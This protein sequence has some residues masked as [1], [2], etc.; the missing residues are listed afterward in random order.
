MKLA[1]PCTY[2]D[3]HG[4]E[5]ALLFN[6]GETLSMTLRDVDFSG[7]DFDDLRPEP[8]CS[9]RALQ[10]FTFHSG[11]LCACTLSLE[12]PITVSVRGEVRTRPLHAHLILGKAR[13]SGSGLEDERLR[14]AITLEGKRYTTSGK[15]GWFDDELE[16]LSGL[17]PAHIF[18]KICHGCALSH[19]PAAGYGL[20]GGLICFKRHKELART[21]AHKSPE[22]WQ[23][24]EEPVDSWVQET[25]VCG[26]FEREGGG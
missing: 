16:E 6:D 14:L 7:S 3:E 21:A 23:L 18:L 4:A 2:S 19:Y 10:K 11:A 25:F 22:Y 20:F 13:A 5:S 1:F 24:F 9:P 12:M 17:L 8:G 26:E 15:F